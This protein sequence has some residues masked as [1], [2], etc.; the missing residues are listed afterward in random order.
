MDEAEAG[1][2][3]VEESMGWSQTSQRSEWEEDH[4]AGQGLGRDVHMDLLLL[5]VCHPCHYMRGLT[6]TPAD[7]VNVL[8][9]R[10]DPVLSFSLIL[11]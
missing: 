9:D 11:S 3:G 8:T 2:F 6:L 5:F 10:E 7:C 1:M 4:Q